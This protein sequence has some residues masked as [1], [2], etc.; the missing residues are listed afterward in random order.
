MAMSG[1]FYSIRLPC[2]ILKTIKS[3]H[4]PLRPYANA[5]FNSPFSE[6]NK[7]FPLNYEKTH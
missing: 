2:G 1:V 7:F 3:A 5:K 6:F 4:A